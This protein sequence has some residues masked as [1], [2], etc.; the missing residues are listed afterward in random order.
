MIGE[1]L[2]G[3]IIS[4]GKK[5]QDFMGLFDMSSKQTLSRKF[6]KDNFTIQDIIKFSDSFGCNLAIIDRSTGEK[7]VTFT[8]EDIKKPEK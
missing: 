7:M 4:K 6:K 8:P 3:F 1:K 2:K 5:M